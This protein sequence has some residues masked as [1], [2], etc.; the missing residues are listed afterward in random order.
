M[1]ATIVFS[2]FECHSL[3]FVTILYGFFFSVLFLNN[4]CI[5]EKNLSAF[6]CF[7]LIQTYTMVGGDVAQL[8]RALDW[9]AADAGSIPWCGKRFFSW[10]QI[11]VQ[12]LLQCLY[13]PV[14]S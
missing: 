4:K 12:T 8:V 9:H 7:V 1:D 6:A 10:S 11:S 3:D 13:T 5:Y 14:C 2:H